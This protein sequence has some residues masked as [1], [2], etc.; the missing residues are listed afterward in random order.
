MHAIFFILALRGCCPST[1][2][3]VLL[4]GRERECEQHGR[5]GPFRDRKGGGCCPP[6]FFSNGTLLFFVERGIPLIDAFFLRS[7]EGV[8]GIE[9]FDFLDGVAHADR[10][11]DVLAF[12]GDTE[13]RVAS[14]QVGC[15]N[16]SDKK[17]APVC[18]KAR[19]G[20]GEYTGFVVLE[21]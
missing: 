4:R 2:V 3:F 14:V 13:N 10:V 9:D 21:A 11:H 6:P 19:I 15:G 12:G 16:M 5:A 8:G 20:H 17:L 1:V 7:E 18:S